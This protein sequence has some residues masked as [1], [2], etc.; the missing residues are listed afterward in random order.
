MQ[1]VFCMGEVPVLV[2][3][4]QL[5]SHISLNNGI[6]TVPLDMYHIHTVSNQ[7]TKFDQHATTKYVGVLMQ[8]GFCMGEVL[9]G[10]PH[11]L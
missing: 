3:W 9:V 6:Q 7:V 5:K 10:Q 2:T 1:P 8:P 4:G 11:G